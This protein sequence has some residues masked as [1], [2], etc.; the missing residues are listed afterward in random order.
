MLRLKLL[1]AF[2]L[3]GQSIFSWAQGPC[4]NFLRTAHIPLQAELAL[5]RH[6]KPLLVTYPFVN[7]VGHEVLAVFY[8]KFP[9][10]AKNKIPE[11][12]LANTKT[13]RLLVLLRQHPDFYFFKK[14]DFKRIR[15]SAN[16]SKEQNWPSFGGIPQTPSLGEFLRSSSPVP[17]AGTL[18]EFQ[19]IGKIHR[20]KAIL[21][22]FLRAPAVSNPHDPDQMDIVADIHQRYLRW[23]IEVMEKLGYHSLVRETI[24]NHIQRLLKSD[25]D[26]LWVP[27]IEQQITAEIQQGLH[28]NLMDKIQQLI[29]VDPRQSIQRPF[30][31]N[32]KI[33]W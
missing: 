15:Y 26:G 30:W 25:F 32:R 9:I 17:A 18:R 20:A 29:E 19:D 3:V 28:R 12:T 11:L 2:L 6:H 13:E 16:S 33:V 8:Y 4:E 7:D 27:T 1:V 22:P 5:I 31:P 23:V 14:K 10:N 24:E 21:F